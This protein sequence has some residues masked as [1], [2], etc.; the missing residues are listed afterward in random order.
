MRHIAVCSASSYDAIELELH[1]MVF[2][3]VKLHGR[4]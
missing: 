4:L 3:V 2:E 1:A